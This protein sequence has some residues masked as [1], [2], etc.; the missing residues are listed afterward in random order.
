MFAAIPCRFVE[1][2]RWAD[3]KSPGSQGD[4]KNA[5]FFFIEPALA[6]TANG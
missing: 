2:K 5:F 3:F 1:A 4:Y 6:G